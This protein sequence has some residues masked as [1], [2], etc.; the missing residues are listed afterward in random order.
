MADLTIEV[1]ISSSLEATVELP[2]MGGDPV[3]II[4]QD[5]NEIAVV[6]PGGTYQVEVL[7]VIRDTITENTTTITDPII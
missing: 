3:S 5:E 1:L 6:Q 7:T 4:D 2:L